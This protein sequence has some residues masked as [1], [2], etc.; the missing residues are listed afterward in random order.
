MPAIPPD[1]FEGQAD[2]EM[3]YVAAATGVYATHVAASTAGD[4]AQ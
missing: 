2:A 3:V 4:L 1:T